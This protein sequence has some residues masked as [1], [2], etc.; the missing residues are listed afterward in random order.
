MPVATIGS[1]RDRKK[2]DFDNELL[3]L[4]RSASL[5]GSCR[6]V[7][8]EENAKS[9]ALEQAYIDVVPPADIHFR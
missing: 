9:L 1:G 7:E 3:E 2:S 6:S 5:N 4:T 8:K